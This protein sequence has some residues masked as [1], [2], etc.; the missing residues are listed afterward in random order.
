MSALPGRSPGDRGT[1]RLPAR[2]ARPG[3]SRRRPHRGGRGRRPDR[4]ARRPGLPLRGAGQQ[5]GARRARLLPQRRPRRAVAADG[6]RRAAS[7]TSARRCRTARAGATLVTARPPLAAFN[8]EL[9]SGD[10]EVARAVAAGLR[11]SGGGL[12]RRAGDRP[13]ALQRPRPGLDQRPRPARGAARRRSSSGCARWPRRSARARSRPSWSASIPEAALAGYPD[14]VPIRGFD[15]DRHVI[16][17]RLAS[18]TD[19]SMSRF[20]RWPRPRR[21]AAAST[22]H[23]GRPH[24][25]QPPHRPA[26]Q[27]RGGESAG[28]RPRRRQSGPQGRPRRRPGAA[29]STAAS[30]PRLI[31]TALLLADLPP[32]RSARRSASAPS[33][34][35]S[36]SRPATTST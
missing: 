17:R 29:R 20:R 31:F 7:P 12:P 34:S 27:P 36:T 16:E 24:R 6:G 1:R 3:R 28:P 26:A 14:D 8:V 13:A 30:S 2:L 21:S 22:G 4:R 32:R 9:D 23:P 10:V 5:P 15:P 18:A 25:H 19:E 11:E 33:C 35:S